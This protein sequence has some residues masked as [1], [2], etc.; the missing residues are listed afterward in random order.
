MAVWMFAR[1]AVEAVVVPMIHAPSAAAMDIHRG[2]FNIT[3]RGNDLSAACN[4]QPYGRENYANT[5]DRQSADPEP[6]GMI[7]REVCQEDPAA[8]CD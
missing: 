7:E 4:R 6:V 3:V 5:I 8:Y 1:P 2:S